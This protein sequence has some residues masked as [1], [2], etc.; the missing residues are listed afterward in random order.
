MRE[1]GPM[2]LLTDAD[3]TDFLTHHP[4]W[5]IQGEILERTFQFKDFI[6][7]VGFVTRVAILAE[8]AFHHPDIDIRWSK[9]RIALTTHDEGG[10]TEKDTGLAGSIEALIAK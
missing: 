6:D 7:A 9:V 3:R 8:K 5:E 4:T 1:T 10:L 2:P